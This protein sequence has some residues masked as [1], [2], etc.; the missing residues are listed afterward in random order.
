MTTTHPL[1]QAY[2]ERKRIPGERLRADGR[3]TLAIGERHRMQMQ[4]LPGGALL[5]EAR[6]A[7]LP[8][9]PRPRAERIERLLRV[10][11][12]RLP[13]HGQALAID[14][15]AEAFV[16]QQRVAD[17]LSPVAFERA[18]ENFLRALVFWHHV[19]SQP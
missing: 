4:P 7:P 8:A 3:L 1:V 10:A 16:L 2:M 17:G 11:A 12:T 18:V 13:R 9:T 15:T 19:E 6:L 5:F 14:A